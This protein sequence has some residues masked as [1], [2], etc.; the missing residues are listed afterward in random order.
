MITIAIIVKIF[1]TRLRGFCFYTS[2]DTVT[3]L[4]VEFQDFGVIFIED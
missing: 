3:G 1:L 2:T 4:S